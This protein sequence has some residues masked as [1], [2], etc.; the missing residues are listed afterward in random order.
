M[1]MLNSDP[2]D[3]GTKQTEGTSKIWMA[4]KDTA[5]YALGCLGGCFVG[6]LAICLDIIVLIVASIIALAIIV[7]LI[8]W[9][10]YEHPE[11]IL[12]IFQ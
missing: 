8:D 10:I 5:A 12:K 7:F 2:D 3:Q 11:T 1:T 6:A 9:V 4:L